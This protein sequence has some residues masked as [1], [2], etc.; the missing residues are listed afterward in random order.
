MKQ[1]S[2][3]GQGSHRRLNGVTAMVWLLL[4][5]LCVAPP[6]HA[7][8]SLTVVDSTRTAWAL[9]NPVSVADWRGVINVN[10]SSVT[11]GRSVLTKTSTLSMNVWRRACD[12]MGCMESVMSAANLPTTTAVW[13]DGLANARVVVANVPVRVQRFR[14]GD[15]SLTEIDD[16]VM[17]MAVSVVAN[18]TASDF[19]QSSTSR[20]AALTTTSRVLRVKA[21][22]AVNIG[23][24]RLSTDDGSLTSSSSLTTATGKA[25][26]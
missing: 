16:I 9:L 20:T 1:P 8:Q 12:V 3:P 18:R 2:Q 21:A 24:L 6:A 13:S 26:R 10:E 25:G 17:L 22:A 11:D 7:A 14:V 15:S 23:S 5:P 19:S 4:M